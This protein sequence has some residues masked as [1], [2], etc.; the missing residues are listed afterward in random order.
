MFFIITGVMF[1]I[2]IPNINYNYTPKAG[3]G[4][5]KHLAANASVGTTGF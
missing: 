5:V 2:E 3:A 1:A 4:L